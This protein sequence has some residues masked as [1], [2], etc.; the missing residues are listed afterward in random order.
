[1]DEDTVGDAN[2]KLDAMFDA[3]R[4]MGTAFKDSAERGDKRMDAM[5][6]RFKEMDSKRK[7][8]EE[9]KE[10]KVPGE[11]KEAAADKGRKDAE[12]AYKSEEISG[13][14]RKDAEEE[15]RK[16]NYGES[17]GVD[18]MIAAWKK[19]TASEVKE[20]MKKRGLGTPSQQ[21]ESARK[22]ARKDSE[23]EERKDAE[24]C[25]EGEVKDAR[26]DKA[27]KDEDA[28]ADAARRVVVGDELASLRA[29]MAA[30]RGRMPA[31]LS[32]T[33]RER[34]A[35]IQ[36]NAEPAF[37]AFGD[38]A[39]AALD[40]ETPLDY[41]RRLAK[42]MQGHS[43]KWAGTRLSGIVDEATLD[44]VVEQIFADSIVAAERGAEVPVGKLREHTERKPTG[45]I[46][47]TFTGA[48]DAWMR[49]HVGNIK[50]SGR[51]A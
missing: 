27:R 17:R 24:E 43:T 10:V 37:Q 51:T 31:V 5:E 2:K 15:E 48:P 47:N 35:A 16:D 49:R 7:D 14:L 36:E 20:D 32:D 40:G 39:G 26:K 33:D 28:M 4:D 23:E 50:R 45:H 30:L 13:T 29:E 46:H 38:K 19:M 8:S 22:Y 41:K 9:S 12:E 42:K 18:A 3:I 44:I 1:M 21:E 6:D 25:K 11:P 34:F